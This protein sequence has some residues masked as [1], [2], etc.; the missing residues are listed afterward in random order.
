MEEPELNALGNWAKGLKV[1][2]P[3]RYHGERGL[4]SLGV[5]MEC[6]Y[7]MRKALE[8]VNAG[9]ELTWA[10]VH[11]MA[12]PMKEVQQTIA[13]VV[14]T[15][16]NPAC[17]DAPL[18]IFSVSSS[19]IPTQNQSQETSPEK[20]SKQTGD[21]PESS[22]SSD[23][24]NSSSTSGEWTLPP[25]SPPTS[26]EDGNTIDGPP[27]DN[28]Y[29]TVEKIE[30]FSGGY[31]MVAHPTRSTLHLAVTAS[32]LKT[33]CGDV[34]EKWATVLEVSSDEAFSQFWPMC[35]RPGCFKHIQGFQSRKTA[36]MRR[37]GNPRQI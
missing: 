8:Q 5:K 27:A 20:T 2:M 29:G 6:V 35:N 34:M 11:S 9:D 3:T 13:K 1:S 25:K 32:S 30:L 37:S 16:E 31:V 28:N 36:S 10:K 4:T 12:P 14:A 18:P 26:S 22:D 17:D 24:Q 15:T 21:D 7:G 23:D 19:M 33:A